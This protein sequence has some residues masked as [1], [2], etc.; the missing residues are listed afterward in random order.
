MDPTSRVPRQ[1]WA[2][3]A[4]A[5]LLV[6]AWSAAAI[7]A[8]EFPSGCVSC[9]VVLPDGSMIAGTRVVGPR[10]GLFKMTETTFEPLIPLPSGGDC[11]YPGTGESGENTLEGSVHSEN[12][13][14]GLSKSPSRKNRQPT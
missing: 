8:D 10:F 14:T 5:G 4:V 3:A 7:P 12:E 2:R 9:H 6:L 13:Y 11:S 1:R